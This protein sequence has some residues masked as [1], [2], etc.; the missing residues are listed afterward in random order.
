M[1]KRENKAKEQEIRT[2]K[3]QPAKKSDKAK[4]H[5][6]KGG[7][8]AAKAGKAKGEDDDDTVLIKE[9]PTKLWNV[10]ITLFLIAFTGLLLFSKFQQEKFQK[11]NRYNRGDTP[12]EVFLFSG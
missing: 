3:A 11:M 4:A 8:K 1:R 9:K 2:T 12:Q 7:E 10:L 5:K 6:G